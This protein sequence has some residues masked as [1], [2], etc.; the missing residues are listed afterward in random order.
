MPPSHSKHLDLRIAFRPFVSVDIW[1]SRAV[2]T[3]KISSSLQYNAHQQ[4][5]I[6]NTHVLFHHDSTLSMV[7]KILQYAELTRRT[8]IVVRCRLYFADLFLL[9]WQRLNSKRGPVCKFLKPQGFVLT[10][11]LIGTEFQKLTSIY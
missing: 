5:L 3:H 6:I 10:T 4:V 11:L 7:C 9:L 1:L 8:S 2:A